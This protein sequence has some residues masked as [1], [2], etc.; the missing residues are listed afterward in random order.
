[1]IKQFGGRL[2]RRSRSSIS[3]GIFNLQAAE[4]DDSILPTSSPFCR[5]CRASRRPSATTLNTIQQAA[6]KKAPPLSFDP[7]APC[8]TIPAHEST[9]WS[10]KFS[11]RAGFWRRR[12]TT[13]RPNCGT[14]R[15]ANCGTRCAG[16]NGPCAGSA[17]T[18]DG[19]PTLTSGFDRTI[20]VWDSESGVAIK[21]LT[22]DAPVFL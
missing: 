19:R 18:H 20:R 13:A 6:F 16:N 11:L 5:N 21:T 4:N 12:A 3:L 1:L 7:A 22:D 9:I 17:F 14:R 2:V 8:W 15:P 10:V